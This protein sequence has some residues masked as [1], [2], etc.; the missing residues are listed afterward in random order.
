MGLMDVITVTRAKTYK[1]ASYLAYGSLASFPGELESVINPTTYALAAG[2]TALCPTTPDGVAITRSEEVTDG[3]EIDQKNYNL[4]EG[5]PESWGMEVSATLLDTTVD[6]IKVIWETPDPVAVSGSSVSQQ[7]LPIGAPAAATE[8]ELYV[9]QEDATN[10]R[11][12]VFAFRKAVVQVDSEV[13]IQS[14]DAAGLPATWRI[15]A[16][17]TIAEHHGPYGFIFEEDA[18]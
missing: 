8:R 16:D 2:L 9:I 14:S 17:A 18:S 11:L 1:G 5:E 15:R 13:N 7:R 6:A 3:I 4:D 12:R 10:G